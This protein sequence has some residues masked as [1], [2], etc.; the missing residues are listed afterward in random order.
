MKG[1]IKRLL[2]VILFIPLVVFVP[3]EM[4]FMFIFTWLITGELYEG[5]PIVVKLI[6]W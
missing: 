2:K 3:V 5:D 6:E 1:F 4:T